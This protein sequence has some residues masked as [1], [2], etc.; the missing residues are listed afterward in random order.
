MRLKGKVAIVTGAGTGIGRAIALRFAGEG[1]AVVLN[2]RREAPLRQVAA[3]L[4]SG[5]ARC[6]A[7]GGDVT[8]PGDV[9]RLVAGTL[10]AFG[11]VDVLVNNAGAMITRTTAGDCPDDDWARTFD[12]NLTSVFRCARGALPA[13]IDARGCIVNV[14]SV[15]GLKGSPSLAA[16]AAAKAAVVNL[17]RTMALEN[18]PHGVRVNAVCPGYVETDLNRDFLA[19]LRQAGG[20]AELVARHPLGLGRPDDVAASALYL[21]S[22]DARWVTGVALPVDG[23]LMAGL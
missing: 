23:G 1:A 21:A 10:Q 9:D 17:T 16:Y 2:G 19:R 4:Q 7:V 5:G 6:L 14:A 11:R 18:A 12:A 15:A 13:L 22:D 20:Y 3:Q 8:R